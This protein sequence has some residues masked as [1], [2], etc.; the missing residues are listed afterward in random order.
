VYLAHVHIKALEQVPELFVLVRIV[1]GVGGVE[2]DIHSLPIGKALVERS[3]FRRGGFETLVRDES[4]V[5]VFA[6]P[7]DSLNMGSVLIGA[8]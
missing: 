3:E 2:D 6:V 1:E 7:S 5:A 4:G 8:G